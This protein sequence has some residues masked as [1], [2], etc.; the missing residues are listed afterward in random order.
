MSTSWVLKEWKILLEL[1]VAFF[2]LK[3]T[4]IITE[5]NT[6]KLLR[7]KEK[8]PFKV[9]TGRN[10]CSMKLLDETFKSLLLPKKV[11]T[12]II[13]NKKKLINVKCH[14]MF[15]SESKKMKMM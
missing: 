14:S 7:I 6:E 13:K 12:Y 1:I 10:F 2:K 4:G 3:T 9:P 15:H 11:I 5:I 8:G